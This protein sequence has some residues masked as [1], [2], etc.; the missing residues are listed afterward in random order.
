MKNY[1]EYSGYYPAEFWSVS[2]KLTRILLIALLFLFIEHFAKADFVISYDQTQQ[3][4]QALIN[5]KVVDEFGA[6]MPGVAIVVKGTSTGTIT[7][8]NGNYSININKGEIL[9]FSFIGMKTQEFVVGDQSVI[10]VSLL[11]DVVGLDDV[12]VVGYGVQKKA[13]LTGAVTAINSETL[14]EKGSLSSPLQALQGQVPGVMVSRASS[15]PGDESWD[16]K[17]R[18][19]SSVNS[20]E[21]LIIVDG[22]AYN[23]VNDL[24]LLNSN[25]IES[26]NFLKDGAAAIYGSRAAGGVVLITTKK[27]KSGDVK[28]EYSGTM[29]FK[30]VGLMPDLMNTNQWADGVMTALE[31]DDNTSNVWY[32][33]AQLAKSYKGKYIDLSESANPFGNSAFTDVSDFVFCEDDWL[34]SLFGDSY[35]T[36][37]NLSISGG[38]ERSSYRVSMSYLY[39]GS[40]L[41]YG[42]N[43][44][45]RYTFRVN[46]SYSFT[47][48]ATLESV[49]SYNRQEQVAPTFIGSM[50]TTSMPMP[51]LPLKSLNGKPYAWGTWGSPVAKAEEGGDNKLSVS[52]INISETFKYDV[53]NWLDANVNVGYNTSS[54]SRHVTQNSISFY[55]YT[56]TDE[57]LT[58]PTQANSYYK[59][60]NAQTDFYS[61]SGYLNFKKSLEDHAFKLM[62]GSQYEFKQYTYFGV[63]VLDTQEGLEIVN[64]SGEISL[65]GDEE[66]YQNANTSFFGRL[67]YDYKSKYLLEFN[68]RYDGS[69]KFLPENRW[70]LFY[71]A[72]LGW[73]ISEENFLKDVSWLDQLKFRISYAEMGNQ[74]GISNYD[75]VQLYNISS[76]NGAYVGDSKLSY[77]KTSGVL[78]STSRSWERIKNYNIGFDFSV[79]NQKLSGSVDAFLKKNDNMLVSITFPSVLGDSAPKANSGEFK[80]WGYEGSFT[81]RDKIGAVSYHVGGV[82]SF[83]RNEL[84]DYGGT[85]VIS[86][87]YTST[88]QGYSLNS[89]FGLRYGGKIQ[90]LEML[91][92]YIAKYY[93]NNGIEMPSNL[94]VGD[95]MYCDLNKDGVL[96]EQDYEYLGSDTPEI[97]YSFNAGVSYKGFDLD[98]LFQ[99]AANRFVYRDIDNWTVPF[100]ANYTNTT[101]QSIGRT[102]NENNPNA[103]YAPYTNDSNLNNYN[104][105]ASSLTAQDGR[106]IRLKNLT[107]GY[108]LPSDKMFKTKY[109]SGFRIYLTG[110]DLWESTKIKDGWDPEA[111]RNAA[112]TQRYPFTRS[113]TVGINLTF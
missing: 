24:R 27:G 41:Q 94:R 82:L 1:D 91:D 62:V 60:T 47:D 75:G 108:S 56:G 99:G 88:Q 73:R 38:T 65:S 105:Q 50:L 9:V 16:L 57:V 31:N 4:E 44:N 26:M 22:V 46:N 43:N 2:Q 87:G 78:A 29:A 49:I 15:A 100:R 36:E 34:G 20:M 33:F 110:T 80:N 54:A 28:F 113:Y 11:S 102:W 106:Y 17:L 64:G 37:N 67:N 23:S 71:G 81:W 85:S 48:K 79:L 101:T 12:V 51:G 59:Q 58:S 30:K 25:D 5:G 86:S 69:S 93:E 10:N 92:A 104:Y 42:N 95:N 39:D 63:K 66:K 40:N 19:S 111:K 109:I 90:N 98:L 35:S 76:S 83:A 53:T 3:Q 21:P 7:D 77:L 13:T 97:S 70:D 84:V 103:Y 45:K 18:G 74:S 55:N 6:A 68:S 32:T 61:L 72:S 112:G 52:A 107:L 8:I 89:I 96:D 14:Q